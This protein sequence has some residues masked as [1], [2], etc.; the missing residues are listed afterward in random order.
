MTTARAL[1]EDVAKLINVIGAGEALPAADAKDGLNTLNDL[2]ESLGL[3]GDFLFA[4]TEESYPLTGT[5]EFTMGIGGDFNTVRPNKITSAFVRKNGIDT[6]VELIDPVTYGQ[7]SNK[8]SVGTPYKLSYDGGF[9]LTKIKIFPVPDSGHTLFLITEKPIAEIP[10][11]T[12][13]LSFPPGYK[14]MLKYNLAVEWAPYFEREAS[15]TVQKT[16]AKSLFNVK[17][18]NSSNDPDRLRMDDG[19]TS[20]SWVDC[21]QR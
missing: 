13:E 4:E 14:R 15:T 17:S 11:L 5:A 3:E 19:I 8:S 7:L 1:I 10:A 9:P 18:N 6:E 21:Y 16:A 2:I 20:M 12:T